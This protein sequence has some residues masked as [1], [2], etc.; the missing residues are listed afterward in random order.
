M[1]HAAERRP[2]RGGGHGR[3]HGRPHRQRDVR[4][5]RTGRAIE[6]GKP[7]IAQRH[8]EAAERERQ[9]H[10]AVFKLESQTTAE[11]EQRLR[12]KV[13]EEVNAVKDLHEKV[14]VLSEG[15]QYSSAPGG[16][17]VASGERRRPHCEMHGHIVTDGSYACVVCGYDPSL[18]KTLT[19][20]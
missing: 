16:Y 17:I 13:E 20:W 6:T 1:A 14:L 10:E 12:E 11:R 9:Y 4:G 3:L 5:A 19:V 8:H 18:D 15:L 2:A 7:A